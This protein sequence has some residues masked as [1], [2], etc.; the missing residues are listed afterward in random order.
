MIGGPA[1]C[2]IGEVLGAGMLARER[3]PPA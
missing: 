2:W 3:V 1:G